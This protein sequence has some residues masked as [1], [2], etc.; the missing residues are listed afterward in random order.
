MVYKFKPLELSLD[1]QDRSYE[2][3]DTINVQVMLTPNSDV[4]VRRGRVDLV[5]E[6]HYSQRGRTFVPDTYSQS[7]RAGLVISGRTRDVGTE[8]KE[9]AVHS[10]V[11][12]LEA[13]LLTGG[14]P[15]I[16][17]AR[18][19]VALTPPPHFEDARALQLDSQSSW[20]F[21][22][23]LIATIDIVRGRNPRVQRAVK[24]MLPQA[25]VGS[26]LGAKPRM[27]T[28]KKKTGSAPGE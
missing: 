20:T 16:R 6:E 17:A 12:L 7:S 26:G 19:L 2:L 22:W 21:K 14:A 8:R 23:T 27:S 1:F 10:T 13:S 18:L 5:C 24:V 3:G 4:D 11:S 25:P 15:S 9:R 28:P